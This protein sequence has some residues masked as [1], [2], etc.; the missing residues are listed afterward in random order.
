MSKAMI[1]H[2]GQTFGRMLGSVL[3][4]LQQIYQTRSVVVPFSASGTAGLEATIVNTLSPGDRVLALSCGAFGDR[5]A[6]I[7]AAF[8]AEVI[9]IEAE[10]GAP[11]DPGTVKDALRR[12]RGVKAV[13]VTH[14][15]T[16]TGVAN[17]LQ[18]LAEAVR[19]SEAL[20]LVD[21]VSSLGAIELQADAWGLDVVV[22]GSQKALMGPPGM[23][24]MS[25]SPRAWSAV[26]TARMPKHYFS[27]VQAR[28]NLTAAGAFTPFTPALPVVYAL[29][30][31]IPMILKEGL[32]SRY[33]RHK[34]L[35]RATRGG[36]TAL[37]LEIF[38]KLPWAS[39]TVTAVRMPA[40]LDVKGLLQHLEREDKVILQ[41]GQGRLDG[42][43]IRIGHMGY[44][45]QDQIVDALKALERALPRFGHP[46]T[47][48]AAVDAAE[49]VLVAP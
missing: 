5:F 32:A 25:V 36:I 39:D 9:R 4:G 17:P 11:N 2:R 48:G 8:G 23:V 37:R 43:I 15:E 1:N 28:D 49:Q 38:P 20:L 7:A 16:S 33:A 40:G 44:V 29:D 47:P 22:A 46:V 27:F 19:P 21:A 12:H 31:S 18:A 45:Q 34:R 10:W 42:K 13:L 3:S 6:N 24:F 41:G 14:N 26:E 30:V 35:A